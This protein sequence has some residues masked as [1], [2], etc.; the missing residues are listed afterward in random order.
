MK[1][2]VKFFINIFIVFLAIFFNFSLY[3]QDYIVDVK[4]YNLKEGL[5]HRVVSDIHE[6]SRGFIW[7]GTKYGIN[8][9]DGE[10]FQWLTKE[11]QGLPSNFIKSIYEDQNGWLWVFMISDE[12]V[13]S[14]IIPP[15]YLIFINIHTLEVRTPE[16]YL[17]QDIPIQLNTVTSIEQP[18]EGGFVFMTNNNAFY[19]YQNKTFKKISIPYKDVYNTQINDDNNILGVALPSYKVV[20]FS[21]TGKV[22]KEYILPEKY[23]N[24]KIHFLV[25]IKDAT[26]N[27]QYIYALKYKNLN[28]WMLATTSSGDELEIINLAPTI[29]EN[30]SLEQTFYNPKNDRYWLSEFGSFLSFNSDGLVYDFSETYPKLSNSG[31]NDIHFSDKETWVAT[32]DGLFKIKLI[33]NPFSSYLKNESKQSLISLNNTCRGILQVNNQLFVNVG[34]AKGRH[35]ID[36]QNKIVNKIDEKEKPYSFAFPKA[37]FKENEEWIWFTATHATRYNINTGEE[38]IY[39]PPLEGELPYLNF[40]WSMYQD[41]NG[42]IWLG[43]DNGLGYVEEKSKRLRYYH[44]EEPFKALENNL[45]YYFLELSRSEVLLATS[46]G[47]YVFNPIKGKIVNRYWKNGK[48]HQYFPY[49]NIHHIYKDSDGIFWVATAGGGLIRW[50]RNADKND[51]EQ[52]TVADGLSNNTLYAVYEDE[53]ENLWL[54]SDYGI[55]VFNKSTK[56]SK[57]YLVEDGINQQEFNRISHYQAEDGQLFFGG[58]NGITA[59]YPEEILDTTT[60]INIPLEI[61]QLSQF[62][63]DANKIVDKTNEVIEQSKIVLKPNERF[64]DL[65]FALL[66]FE[67][68]SNIRYAYM[69]EGVDKDWT[70][71]KENNV[72]I[73]GLPYGTHQLIVKGQN[74]NGQF[75]SQQINL[76]IHVIRPFYLRWWFIVLS[77]AA[78][79]I[80]VYLWFRNRTQRLLAYQNQLE[81]EVQIRTEQIRKDKQVIEEQAEELKNL[82]NVKSTFFA[83]ISHELRTP[84][85]LMLAPIDAALKS[86]HLPQREVTFL[87]TAKQSGKQLLKL[88]NSILDLSKLEANKLEIH[89]V[90]T[91]FFAFTRRVVSTFEALAQNNNIQLF[92]DYQA[93]KTLRLHL[94]R[95][96]LEIVINNLLSNAIKFTPP[97]GKVT[98]TIQDHHNNIKI[99]VA[100]TGRGIHPDDL[101]YVFNRFYQTKQPNVAAEGG[102]G[103]GLAFCKEIARLFEGDISVESELGKGTT[104]CFEFPRVEIFETMTSL[105][106][107]EDEEKEIALPLANALEDLSNNSKI[108]KNRKILLVEDNPTLRNFLKTL[109]SHHEVIAAGNG[110]EALEQLKN[111]VPD[112]IISDVMMPVMDG[113]QLLDKLK[114]NDSYR[115]IPML[116]LTARASMQDK[117]KALRIGVDDYMTKPFEQ[118]EL[119]ARVDNLLKNTTERTKWITEVEPELDK[120][121]AD[122]TIKEEVVTISETDRAWLEELEGFV[123]KYLS[124]SRLNT[125]YLADELHM[126]RSQLFRRLKKITGLSPSQYIKEFRLKKAYE[127]LEN[128]TY[129]SI[130]AVSL[131]VGIT[132]RTTFNTQFKE[133][134][135]KLPSDYL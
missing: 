105:E 16:E 38:I 66:N 7:L 2:I 91:P 115:H 80:G 112:L 46:G 70:Y 133:R 9:F 110:V 117:L 5:S 86:K 32:T 106:L 83:N 42:Q 135:G 63:A 23:K 43:S 12:G 48:D 18:K 94:D 87:Q 81:Q 69:V 71:T 39:H 51:F 84:L 49:N 107:E 45:V 36:L 41:A 21:L 73:S 121:A 100:D 30:K 19:T 50:E 122:Q 14:G 25:R 131:S 40:I 60:T 116:M 44:I 134:F 62:S 37:I 3:A 88:I 72:R 4:Q 55:N 108:A 109:L 125:N 128:N 53:K 11:K 17:G 111:Y 79:V 28:D 27:Q 77:M 90:P 15:D 82:D 20:E 98:V 10:N 61:V 67:N 74:P 101:P 76:P 78:L 58:L 35:V 114:S 13:W 33:E 54:P 93:E 127:L 34:N 52:F 59:F 64:F 99:L 68:S 92:F 26:Y 119:Y 130:K 29:L 47:I 8:R 124:D 56:F 120:E 31:V 103:I 104:F 102:T 57:A 22:I 126:S 6:D 97:K 95:E 1:P 85:T 75:S 113:F 132:H 118:D 89:P 65:T 123:Q 129:D 96:K 24:E